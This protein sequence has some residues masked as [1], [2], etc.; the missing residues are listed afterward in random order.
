MILVWHEKIN[1]SFI[2]KFPNL[3]GVVRYGVGFDNI[4]LHYAA[5][6]GIFVCNTP[7]YGIDEVSDTAIS[8][9][10]NISRGI[11]QYDFLC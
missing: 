10:L 5:S 11:S 1:K 7:D 8:M 6:K 4:D 3:K 9:I 2:D